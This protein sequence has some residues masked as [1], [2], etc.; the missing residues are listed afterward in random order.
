MSR[1]ES[2]W[3]LATLVGVIFHS[4]NPRAG[5][6]TQHPVPAFPGAEGFGAQTPGGR[7]GKVLAVTNLNDKGPGS[8]RA[9]VEAKGPRIVI[10]RVAGIITLQSQLDT[11]NPFITIAGQTAP[12]DGICLA[13]ERLRIST[14]DV[15]VRYLRSRLGDERRV[16]TDAIAV[17]RGGHD[18]ILDHCSTSWAVDETLSV[19]YGKNVTVQWCI[20]AESLNRSVHPKGAHGYG[21]LING[22]EIMFHHNLYAHHSNRVPRP[23]ICLLDFR[24]NVLYDWGGGGYNHGEATRMN[25]VGNYLKPGPSRP[26]NFITFKTGGATRIYLDGNFMVGSADATAHNTRLLKIERAN[27]QEVVVG[28]PFPTAPVA[29]DSAQKAFER[30]LAE[31]GATLPRRDAVDERIIQQVKTGKG[32][33]I[34]SQR[35]VGGYPEYRFGDP[36]ADTDGDGMP[37]EWEKKFGLN[38]SDP[39]D[40]PRDADGDGYTNVEEFLNATDPRS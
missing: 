40:G 34:D 32:R 20:I 7:G 15:V 21:S 13:G 2:L 19:T 25:Y 8:L 35:D 6:I 39:L 29:T 14:H 12:G 38:L 37:D 18:V 10:F 5:Q 31:C 24:N 22:E 11:T 17:Y 26:T 16:A 36:P 33:I 4:I 3:I 1:I 23:A 27:L 9:A 28:K 30:V